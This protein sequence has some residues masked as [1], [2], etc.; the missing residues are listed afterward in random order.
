M[1]KLVECLLESTEDEELIVI[2]GSNKKV[3]KHLK[4]PSAQKKD[5]L[6]G[7]PIR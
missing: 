6:F 7:I 4:K 5:L 3:E 2:C 1:G